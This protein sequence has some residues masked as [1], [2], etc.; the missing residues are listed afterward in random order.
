MIKQKSSWWSIRIALICMGVFVIQFIIGDLQNY[1]VLVS[2]YAVF[3]PWTIVTHAFMHGGFSHLLY[4]MFALLIFGP[5]LEKVIGS[6]NF[7]ILYAAAGLASAFISIPFYGAVL[8]ASGA[9]FGIL[10]ALAILRPK[11]TVWVTGFPMPMAVAAAFWAFG[12]FI[13]LFVPSGTANA[14]HLA[15]LF[16]GIG[17]GIYFYKKFKEVK[18]NRKNDIEISG[19]SFDQWEKKWM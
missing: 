1:F 13:G 7:L 8:G 19:E 9:I 15:G 6:K 10:G 12:D 5:I 4:N 16:I 17:F 2:D 18:H 14:A 3:R 11:M